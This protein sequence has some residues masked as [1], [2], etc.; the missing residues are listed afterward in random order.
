MPGLS[1]PT[2][3]RHQQVVDRGITRLQVGLEHKALGRGA[4]LY[5]AHGTFEPAVPFE[6][7][8]PRRAGQVVMQCQRLQDAGI[9]CGPKV[10]LGLIL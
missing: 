5:L 2:F 3:A 7:R 6:V 9:T 1:P 8:A 4:V 10:D